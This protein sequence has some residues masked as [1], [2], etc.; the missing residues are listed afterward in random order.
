MNR[1]SR[2]R[3]S[4]ATGANGANGRRGL[5]AVDHYIDRCHVLV[6]LG[7]NAKRRKLK[8]VISDIRIAMR[9][10]RSGASE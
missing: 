10:R 9:R 5:R 1:I 4:C 2:G 8:M 7:R 6:S 3:A